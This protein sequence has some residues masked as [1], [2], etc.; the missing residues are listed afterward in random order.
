MNVTG[1]RSV[2][3]YHAHA[4][5]LGGHLTRPIVSPLSTKAQC[6]LGPGGGY[7]TATDENYR[8]QNLISFE[9]AVT[10]VHGTRN[11]KAYHC[12]ASVEITN[13][14]IEN[15]VTAD[16]ITGKLSSSV[17][18]T[19]SDEPEFSVAGCQFLNLR[20]GGV[21]V[22]PVLAIDLHTRLNTHSKLEGMWGAQ[23]DPGHGGLRSAV[24]QWYLPQADIDAEEANPGAHPI[25]P[26]RR[27]RTGLTRCSLLAKFDGSTQHTTRE[28][29]TLILPNFGKI[30]LCEFFV[31]KYSRS[32][33]MLR[34]EMGSP[35]EGDGD[36]G[37]MDMNGS[38]YP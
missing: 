18:M 10:Q 12:S 26:A 13:L 7:Q 20:I 6:V 2:F 15:E 22:A 27:S 32:L 4:S 5:A 24:R 34:L 1:D 38:I 8:L 35:S 33:T 36:V 3:L 37:H 23:G 19:G 25:K 28:G 17:P 14:N 29:M 30:H 21:L 16:R 9:K 31:G 11:D